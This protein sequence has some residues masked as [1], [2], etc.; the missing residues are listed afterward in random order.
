MLKFKILFLIFFLNAFSIYKINAQRVRED[1]ILFQLK[2]Y[3]SLTI[4][5]ED[6]LSRFN[7]SRGIIFSEVS[8]EPLKIYK[9]KLNDSTIELGKLKS[10]LEENPDVENVQFNFITQSR[11]SPND[12]LYNLQ[13][14]LKNTGQSGGIL[15]ADISAESAWNLTTGGVTK[16]G[17]TIVICVVDNG[18]DINHNDLKTNI[19]TNYHEIPENEIDDDSNGFVDDYHGWNSESE[20]GDIPLG[21]HGTSVSGLIGAQSNNI[22]GVA[23]INW[24]VKIMPVFVAYDEA[25]T[26]A[27]YAYAYKMRKLYNE[28]HGAKGAF[29]VATNSSFGVDDEYAADHPIWCSMY[30]SLG[31]VGI[32]NIVATTNS[33]SNVD[34]YGDMPSTCPGDFVVSVTNIDRYDNISSSG[35]GN[36][37][38]DLGGYG[39]N[40]YTIR[41]NNRYTSFSGTSAATPVVT[42]VIGLLYSYSQELANLAISNPRYAALL[43]RDALLEGTKKINSL[44]EN[45]VTGG[46][47]NAYNSLKNLEK[48]E[49]NCPPPS[50]VNV[51]SIGAD[52]VTISWKNNPLGKYNIAYK[53]IDEEWKLIEK[54]ESPYTIQNLDSCSE[55][56]FRIQKVCA[57]T[58]GLFG[59]LTNVK[60]DGCCTSPDIKNY[61]ITEDKI[62]I[63]WDKIMAADSY[64]L[65]YKYWSVPVW[66]TIRTININANI[67][68]NIDCGLI[69]AYVVSDCSDMTSE[70][71]IKTVI[72][73][74]CLNCKSIDYCAPYLDNDYEWIDNIKIGNLS[75]QSGKNIDGYGNFSHSKSLNLISGEDYKL[76]I[77]LE[78]D[79]IVYSDSLYIW[80]DLDHNG[81]FDKNEM[82]ANGANNKTKEVE[83][84]FKI[85]ETLYQGETRMR[86]LLSSY[87][88]SDPCELSD[89]DY[90]EFE[91][92]CVFISQNNSCNIS[93]VGFQTT[94]LENNVLKLSWNS[95]PDAFGYLVGINSQ[96]DPDEFN[97]INFVKDPYIA[98][99]NLDTCSYF[100]VSFTVYCDDISVSEEFAY[101]FKTE[102]SNGIDQIKLGNYSIFPNPTNRF[103]NI[104]SGTKSSLFGVA[105]YDLFGREILRKIDIS[106]DYSLDLNQYFPNLGV[107]LVE[108]I[109]NNR[110]TYFKLIKN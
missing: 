106:N 59:I 61:E 30:D 24:N 87:S 98:Y 91:D 16:N 80:L 42:G 48:F 38:I 6:I 9:I 7:L 21:N 105:I 66:D 60:T 22:K 102:C 18:T 108:I 63:D 32:L 19:W 5:K 39:E 88:N 90:G 37:S 20:R 57:D 55:I 11:L 34:I 93:G 99:L 25:Q 107:Y 95:Q 69:E 101:S 50:V 54:I 72:G 78:F 33:N 8:S 26:I 96:E 35:F 92:Y 12:S 10:Y 56:A 109:E 100:D 47:V 70:N 29:I 103:I 53:P 62:R 2:D 1:Q 75:Y 64:K 104:N 82:I 76:K 52:L 83:I 77:E 68:Y 97:Q 74:E 49:S 85:P 46:V 84:K 15:G 71:V 65:I 51:D 43:A 79:D 36:K 67:N 94:K 31:S 110:H 45:S 40:V 44:T 86:I 58:L 17:D 27:S 73:N 23:G 41:T 81:K 28:T 89:N 14:H 3:A 4:L 13:W